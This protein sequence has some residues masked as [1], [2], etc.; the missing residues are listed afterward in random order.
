MKSLLA[1]IQHLFPRRIWTDFKYISVYDEFD[2]IRDVPIHR[3]IV[4]KDQFGN[5][6]KFKY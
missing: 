5:L 1:I 6:R 4:Q 3:I 2:D